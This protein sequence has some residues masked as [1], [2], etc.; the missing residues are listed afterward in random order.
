MRSRCLQNNAEVACAS[1]A[2]WK[3]L[4][5]TTLRQQQMKSI[6][7]VLAIE[8]EVVTIEELSDSGDADDDAYCMMLQAYCAADDAEG[9]KAGAQQGSKPKPRRAEENQIAICF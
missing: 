3:L 9:V 2:C 4:K 6:C 5:L 8:P 1:T 7:R